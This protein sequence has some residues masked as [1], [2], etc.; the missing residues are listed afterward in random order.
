M[1]QQILKDAQRRN[2]SSE[3]K[4]SCKKALSYAK[5]QLSKQKLLNDTVTLRVIA[6]KDK[7]MAEIPRREEFY[8]KQIINEKQ[9]IIC[10][11]G[12]AT[13]PL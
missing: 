3:L 7:V 1:E 5:Y 9:I 2:I 12:S 8:L 11:S 10:K 6:F 13:L 4:Q